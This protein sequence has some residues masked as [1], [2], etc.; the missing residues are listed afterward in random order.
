MLAKRFVVVVVGMFAAA[1]FIGPA[2]ASSHGGKHSD[3]T[4]FVNL[5]SDDTWTS[6]MALT[7]AG[8]AK[9]AGFPVVVFL[10]VRGVHV[11]DKNYPADKK[12]PGGKTPKELL[13]DLIAKG[14]TVYVCPM[15]S[16]HAGLKQADWVE[17][18]KPGGPETIKIQM[19][20]T[21]KVMSY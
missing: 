18:S 11:A 2:A 5:T 3:A 20:P 9:E 12:G 4:L 6:N 7:Y 19:A 13:E 14:V 1:F 8:K 21:T 17:G 15:C 16:T 10:N